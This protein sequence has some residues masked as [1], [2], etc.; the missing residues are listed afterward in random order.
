MKLT[1]KIGASILVFLAVLAIPSYSGLRS[2]ALKIQRVELT[3][4]HP[5]NTVAFFKEYALVAPNSPTYEVDE[6]EEVEPGSLERLDN[7][8]LYIINTRAPKDD[9]IEVSLGSCYYPTAVL[10]D[11][12]NAFVR[13][14]SFRETGEAY[15]VIACIQLRLE[16]GKPAA[17]R[18]VIVEIP[19]INEETTTSEAPADMVL[20]NDGKYL[21]FTNGVWVFSYNLDEGYVYKVGIFSAKDYGPGN[22]ILFAG[23]DEK[24]NTL[25]VSHNITEE[26]VQRT[27]L[28]FYTLEPTG[29]LSSLK[30]VESTEFPAGAFL[31]AESMVAIS[32]DSAGAPAFAYL[33][34]SDGTIGQ[35]GLHRE[36]V[37]D[38]LFGTVKQIGQFTELAKGDGEAGP[39]IA[40]IDPTGARV[41]IVNPGRV[42]ISI[43]RP[44]FNRPVRAG[45]RRP[46][47]I[48]SEEAPRLFS[49]QMNG[50]R[51]K[52]VHSAVLSD[53][54]VDEASITGLTVQEGFEGILTTHSGRVL[55]IAFTKGVEEPEVDLLGEIGTVDFFTV[56]QQKIV[57]LSSAQEQEDE[58]G[59]LSFSPGSLVVASRKEGKNSSAA[60]GT[61]QMLSS[62]GS[63]LARAVTSIRR[64]CNLGR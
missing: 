52:L 48:R 25:V 27:V 12:R 46:A 44:A 32:A 2:G 40:K 4:T 17:G 7:N 15:E 42:P 9:P 62:S 58:T 59:Q 22:Y 24:T 13:G 23:F 10:C 16:D 39:R 28:R 11:G 53:L 31:P 55:S 60:L 5:T 3:G 26:S 36:P 1:L 30:I 38:D 49:G 14:T 37:G 19:G 47:F 41:W 57:A 61:S 50:K 56:E 54:F 18:A 51:T 33:G 63:V 35:I 45:I 29:T 43:R 8:K 64:P 20:G 21:L 34:L 6:G